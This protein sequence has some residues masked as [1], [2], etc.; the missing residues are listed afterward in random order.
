MALPWVPE[1]FLACGGTFRCWPKAEATSGEAVYKNPKIFWSHIFFSRIFV[2]MRSLTTLES[3]L[4]RCGFG[5][6]IHCFRVDETGPICAVS[7]ISGLV[8]TWP[9]FH[10]DISKCVKPYSTQ[11][12]TFGSGHMNFVVWINAGPQPLFLAEPSVENGWADPDSVSC[13]VLFQTSYPYFMN[14]IHWIRSYGAGVN[15]SLDKCRV[16]LISTG[17]CS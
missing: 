11:N 7:E 1:V 14:L 4:N 9:K 2:W 16:L 8:W 15:R 17:K 13:F 12:C 10:G 5:E 6:R 3:V